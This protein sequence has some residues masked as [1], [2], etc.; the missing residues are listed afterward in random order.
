MHQQPLHIGEAYQTATNIHHHCYNGREEL[1]K[2]SMIQQGSS[3]VPFCTAGMYCMLKFSQNYTCT[4]MESNV[5]VLLNDKE[6]YGL[7][8]SAIKR[9]RAQR[10]CTATAYSH[11]LICFLIQPLLDS[12]FLPFIVERNSYYVT[13][14]QY[15]KGRKLWE[16]TELIHVF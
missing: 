12:S 13:T 14:Q 4:L 3:S 8:N 10:P 1:V 9:P 11:S 6:S 5:V 2:D 7:L 16:R 15:R